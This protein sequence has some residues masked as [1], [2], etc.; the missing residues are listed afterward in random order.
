LAFILKGLT[1]GFTIL[2]FGAGAVLNIFR[3]L[4]PGNFTLFG[5]AIM[6]EPA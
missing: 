6:V 5:L 4:A 3:K 1:A 2:A